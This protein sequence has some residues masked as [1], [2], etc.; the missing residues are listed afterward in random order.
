MTP[1]K[2][3]CISCPGPSIVAWKGLKVYGAEVHHSLCRSHVY[4]ES[5]DPAHHPLKAVA[6][7]TI[8]EFM[9]TVTHMCVQ[10]VMTLPT[11][12]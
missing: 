4:S 2:R 7:F 8:S 11:A 5:H 9:V 1:H 3:F 6:L 12:P 10:R